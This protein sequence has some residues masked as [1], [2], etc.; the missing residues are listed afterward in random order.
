MSVLYR[1]HLWNCSLNLHLPN[2]LESLL[3]LQTTLKIS[4]DCTFVLYSHHKKFNGNCNSLYNPNFRETAL[5]CCTDT[6]YGTVVVSTYTTQTF[7]R[8]C[9]LIFAVQTSSKFYGNKLFHNLDFLRLQLCALYRH[10]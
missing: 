8:L 7:W 3:S 5:L 10:H 9:T 4:G 2:F 1:H 6:I